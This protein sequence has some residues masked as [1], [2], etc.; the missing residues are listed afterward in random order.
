MNVDIDSETRQDV[1]SALVNCTA[2]HNITITESGKQCLSIIKS[3]SCP[4]VVIVGM[5]LS[6]M[7]CFELI[8]KIKEYSNIP[9][10]VISCDTNIETIAKVLEIGA[11]DCFIKP[12]NKDIFI[13]KINAIIRRLNWDLGKENGLMIGGDAY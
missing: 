5:Q 12:L 7:S 8:I 6:D 4:D 10:I 11:S 3:K 13:A 1:I 9:I 2:K